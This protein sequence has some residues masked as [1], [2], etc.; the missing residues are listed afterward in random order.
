MTH[1]FYE[2]FL[3]RLGLANYAIFRSLSSGEHLFLH[4]VETSLLAR[5]GGNVF[6][7]T[8][9]LYDLTF[10][11]FIDVDTGSWLLCFH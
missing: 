3:A 6:I 1:S 10:Q 2:R 11:R 5:A 9:A 4:T 8:V 7:S